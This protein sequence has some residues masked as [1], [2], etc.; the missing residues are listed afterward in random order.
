M[1]ADQPPT[2]TLRVR[3]PGVAAPQ[4]S[5]KHLGKGLPAQHSNAAT[6]LP[7]RR[8]VIA[9]VQRA[10]RADRTEAGWPLLGPVVVDVLFVFQRPK[11]YPG[12]PYPHVYPDL[13]KLARAVLD[14]LGKKKGGGAIGDDAQVV[15]LTAR[16]RYGPAPGVLITVTSLDLETPDP[17]EGTP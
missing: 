6:L 14:C 11:S 1:T 7:W 12:R 4:G 9:H 17:L 10:I 3:V 15:D 13:D 5:I 16:K 8:S 2:P